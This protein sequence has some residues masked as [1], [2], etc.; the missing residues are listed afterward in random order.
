[1]SLLD[2]YAKTVVDQGDKIKAQAD[3]IEQLREAL[4]TI[5]DNEVAE[6]PEVDMIRDFAS[7]KL[8]GFK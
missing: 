6:Y 4:Q 2:D 7:A 3:E 5:A 8:K 1:M